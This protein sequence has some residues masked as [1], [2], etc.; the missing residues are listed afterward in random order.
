MARTKKFWLFCVW[1]ECFL[2]VHDEK[3]AANVF[4][5]NGGKQDVFNLRKLGIKNRE[6]MTLTGSDGRKYILI[7]KKEWLLKKLVDSILKR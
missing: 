4:E 3:V 2:A 7:K 1:L 5:S 6:T